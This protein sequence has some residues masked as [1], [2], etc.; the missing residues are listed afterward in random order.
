MNAILAI[1][2]NTGNLVNGCLVFPFAL[3]IE[4]GSWMPLC[5]EHI[6]QGP[7]GLEAI[8][9]CHYGEQNGDAMRDPEMI[10]EF[11]HDALS[12]KPTLAPYYWRND[13]VGIEQESIWKDDQGRLWTRPGQV[14][15]HK[16]FA[17]IWNANLKHQGFVEASK[18]KPEEKQLDLCPTT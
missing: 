16:A 4:N 10:F 17:K 5:I 14:R 12:N 7:H 15:Q 6:G 2:K 18:P 8:S 13:Y 9:V 11:F 3:K 1:L